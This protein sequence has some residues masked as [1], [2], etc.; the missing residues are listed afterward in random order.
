MQRKQSYYSPAGK[1]V[2]G[3]CGNT[4]SVKEVGA[5]NTAAHTVKAFPRSGTMMTYILRLE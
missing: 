4:G 3:H 1:P 5:P 2:T